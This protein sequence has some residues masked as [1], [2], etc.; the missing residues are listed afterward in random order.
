MQ[1]KV[2]EGTVTVPI[3]RHH[4]HPRLISAVTE[5]YEYLN[6]SDPPRWLRNQLDS[7]SAAVRRQM[8]AEMSKWN[9]PGISPSIKGLDI[10]LTTVF[11]RYGEPPAIIG[12]R[13]DNGCSVDLFVGSRGGS[14]RSRR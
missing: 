1:K 3:P 2:P 7:P 4:R 13:F 10:N 12:A 6:F 9:N 8:L 11:H 14:T 5:R